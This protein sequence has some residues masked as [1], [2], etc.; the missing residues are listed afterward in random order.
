[1][2]VSLS[3]EEALWILELVAR[4]PLPVNDDQQ[5]LLMK[6]RQPILEVLEKDQDIVDQSMYKSWCTSE[7]RKIEGLRETN[8]VSRIRKTNSNRSRRAGCEIMNICNSGQKGNRS[9]SD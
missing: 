9:S 5:L 8:A 3:S 1:M 4:H 6:V 2:I 7:S